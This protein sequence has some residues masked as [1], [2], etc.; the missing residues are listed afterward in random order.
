METKDLDSNQ[1]IETTDEEIKLAPFFNTLKRS[2]FFIALLTS[3]STLYG[4]YYSGTIKPTYR[5]SFEILV[6]D[7]T[8]G[9]PGMEGSLGGLLGMGAGVLGGPSSMT[10]E[11]ILR[12]P[13]VLKPVF[14][15][16]LEEYKKMGVPTEGMNYKQWI[17]SEIDIKFKEASQVLE[18]THFNN[19]KILIAKT[20]NMLSKTYQEFSKSDRERE[21]NNTIQYLEEQNS[22]AKDISLAA[23]K[24][25]NEFSILHGLG[26][27]D[28]FVTLSQNDLE[29]ISDT[30]SNA[31]I[32]FGTQFGL[33]ESYESSYKDYSSKLK[34][35]SKF[36]KELNL[37]IENLRSALKR[38]N[39]ILLKYRELGK[40]AQNGE[41][42]FNAI[43]DQLYAIKFE[44]AKQLDPWQLISEPTVEEKKIAPKRLNI[45][46]FSLLGSLIVS[47]LLSILYERF[48]GNL[49]ELEDIRKNIYCKYL[50]TLYLNKRG[51]SKKLFINSINNFSEASKGKNG[52]LILQDENDDVFD[53]FIKQLTNSTNIEILSYENLKEE[54][55]NSIDNIF[56]L[57]QAGKVRRKELILISKYIKSYKLNLRGWFFL[58]NNF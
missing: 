17:E 56:L 33:L 19:D 40:L 29:P 18:V 12:S 7:K 1:N 14:N 39:E 21:I 36:L 49:Y 15:F 44:K 43:Q 20:L 2:K 45:T 6:T 13:S 51:L 54:N 30:S 26:D 25:F 37:K 38:P 8:V 46:L 35:N 31:G 41:A 42:R 16:V 27:I 34:E 9:A 47:S 24:E 28:G 48:K 57:I 3:V 32:R 22:I 55:L 23:L 50:E 58:V 10:Q 52:L 11:L 53:S 5:G 4:M